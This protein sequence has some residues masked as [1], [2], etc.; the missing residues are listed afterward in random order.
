M[1]NENSA[2]PYNR[3]WSIVWRKLTAEEEIRGLKIRP[4]SSLLGQ[5]GLWNCPPKDW[6]YHSQVQKV[7]TAAGI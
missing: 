1:T 5:S 3:E 2:K 7:I 6:S 4:A